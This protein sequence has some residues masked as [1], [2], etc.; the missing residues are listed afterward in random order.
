MVKKDLGTILKDQRHIKGLT[1]KELAQEINVSH[2]A[3]SRWEKNDSTPDVQNLI[4]LCNLYG[5]SLDSLV[6]PNEVMFEEQPVKKEVFIIMSLILGFLTII[7][8]TFV[9]TFYAN[10]SKYIE[11][12][13]ILYLLVLGVNLIIVNV[14]YFLKYRKRGLNLFL[15]VNYIASTISFLILILTISETI[16]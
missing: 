8:S 13:I 11:I 5:I 10:Q 2:Q 3:I 9:F 15:F 7:M 1:Q 16:D 14:F 6:K 4:L 12:V